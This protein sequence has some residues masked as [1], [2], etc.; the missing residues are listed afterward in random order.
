MS[1]PVAPI[2]SL[3]V[4]HT[5]ARHGQVPPPL[6]EFEGCTVRSVR[7][8]ADDVNKTFELCPWHETEILLQ[9]IRLAP[10]L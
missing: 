4:C 8:W 9:A 1:L 3:R 5:Y 6:C 7:L 10:R 2:G